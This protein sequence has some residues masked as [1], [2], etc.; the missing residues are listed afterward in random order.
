MPKPRLRLPP[1]LTVGMALFF[2]GGCSKPGVTVSG[3]VVFPEKLK[4]SEKEIVQIMFL[5]QPTGDRTVAAVFS[6]ENGTFE[7]KNLVPGS[8]KITVRVDPVPG[9]KEA[10][11]P[12]TE[13]AQFNKSF[14]RA[15]TKLLYE[16]TADSTQ[17]IALD[18]TKGT[19]TKN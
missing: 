8:Y 15:S 19:V 10:A 6:R 16:V 2:A 14:D 1:V 7:C 9:G 12:S 4:V 18:L 11:K 3:T 5:P 17:S 13:M